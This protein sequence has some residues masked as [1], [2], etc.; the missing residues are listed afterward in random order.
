MISSVTNKALYRKL[1]DSIDDKEEDRVCKCGAK[2]PLATRTAAGM[3]WDGITEM[4]ICPRC[5]NNE[6]QEV[7]IGIVPI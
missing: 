4:W 2:G 5:A 3:M 7:I 1:H 6:K